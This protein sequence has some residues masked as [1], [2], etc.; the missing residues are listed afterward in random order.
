[1]PGRGRFGGRRRAQVDRHTSVRFE[2]LRESSSALGWRPEFTGR[3]KSAWPRALP[4][5]AE[6][7]LHGPCAL[8]YR[9]GLLAPGPLARPGARRSHGADFVPAPTSVGAPR[10]DPTARRFGGRLEDPEGETSPRRGSDR[11][12][13]PSGARRPKRVRAPPLG[14][15]P[16]QAGSRGSS[17]LQQSARV[18]PD[19]DADKLRPVQG[20]SETTADPA[21]RDA[22]R[23]STFRRPDRRNLRETPIWSG[24]RPAPARMPDFGPMFGRGPRPGVRSGVRETAE[25]WHRP[26][27]RLFGADFPGRS[28]QSPPFGE[29]RQ[30]PRRLPPGASAPGAREDRTPPSRGTSRRLGP[31]LRDLAPRAVPGGL[32]RQAGRT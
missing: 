23:A 26:A 7:G 30:P 12:P 1:V 14:V 32:A 10:T 28:F 8:V 29:R 18:R 25:A 21:T 24:T 4:A 19:A 22:T 31:G 3:P 11:C 13:A 17:E 6:P 15:E 20:P 2:T 5:T 16:P 27:G 9:V